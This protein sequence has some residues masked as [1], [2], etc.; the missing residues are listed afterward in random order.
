ML[1]Q[2]GPAEGGGAAVGRS[3]RAGG[4]LSGGLRDWILERGAEVRRGG[5]TGCGDISAGAR[6]EAGEG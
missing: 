1:P 4:L 5:R 3:G 6:V 2:V